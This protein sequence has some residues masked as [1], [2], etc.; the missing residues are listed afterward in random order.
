LNKGIISSKP[1]FEQR[2]FPVFWS[3]CSVGWL[4]LGHS[5]AEEF[6]SPVKNFSLSI[7]K[8]LNQILFLVI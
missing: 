1:Q 4:Q 8:P 6:F 5:L 2:I 3:N 7:I